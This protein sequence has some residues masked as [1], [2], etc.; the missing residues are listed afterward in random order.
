REAEAQRAA[1]EAE[2]RRLEQERLAK[3]EAERLAREAEAQR[4]AAEAEQRRLELEQQSSAVPD[5]E[6]IPRVDPE[7][8]A[9]ERQELRRSINAVRA[10]LQERQAQSAS[11]DAWAEDFP[12]Q[13]VV[14][15][16]AEP[17]RDPVLDLEPLAEDVVP[18]HSEQ[19]VEVPP[20]NESQLNPGCLRLPIEDLS[21]SA[22]SSNA[23]HYGGFRTVADLA[24]KQPDD[25]LN[26]RNF[27][28]KSLDELIAGLEKQGIPF[29]VPA[30]PQPE[31]RDNHVA[32]SNQNDKPRLPSS[33]TALRD[34]GI[35]QPVLGPL[36]RSGMN[37]LEDLAGKSDSD[38]AE[39]RNLGPIGIE[40]LRQALAS[41]GLE[42]PFHLGGLELSTPQLSETHQEVRP[43]ENDR[44]QRR[45]HV[46][47]LVSD[48][49]EKCLT[50]NTG[51]P[52][53]A[54]EDLL[55]NS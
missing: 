9:A 34:L 33:T 38:L 49:A 55:Q 50:G 54:I 27:G 32:T 16:R 47:A 46:I 53:G 44:K 17:L 29:P 28:Q 24:E 20:P 30:S 43:T 15:G 52:E 40:R 22:R 13:D 11:E 45:E 18:R 26:I 1:A 36:L 41:I 7:D 35:P 8:L 23:L 4:A 39:I 25:L 10:T 19:I 37:T 51:N 21:L 5:E 2:Q 31:R 14:P 6:D 12:P 42:L 48:V 3:A